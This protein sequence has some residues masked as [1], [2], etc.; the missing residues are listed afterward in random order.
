MLIKESPEFGVS[1]FSNAIIQYIC[2]TSFAKELSTNGRWLASNPL[3]Y[4]GRPDTRK[5]GLVLWR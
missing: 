2:Y 1:G 3:Q 5:G 4:A